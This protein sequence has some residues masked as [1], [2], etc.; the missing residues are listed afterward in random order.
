MSP[1]G[2]DPPG[3]N[4]ARLLKK[5]NKNKVNKNENQR[6]LFVSRLEPKDS[7]TNP[8]TNVS[9]RLKERFRFA[10]NRKEKI[11]KETHHITITEAV[12]DISTP[13][14]SRGILNPSPDNA[15]IV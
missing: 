15:A 9:T 10:I 2:E 14:T 5:T 11:S 13:N 8:N 3:S 7:E 4:P 12:M 6:G 1:I